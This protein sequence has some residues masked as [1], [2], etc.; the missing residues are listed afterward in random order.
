MSQN[1]SDLEKNARVEKLGR[2]KEVGLNTVFQSIRFVLEL[3]AN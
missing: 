3:E 1:K 2:K